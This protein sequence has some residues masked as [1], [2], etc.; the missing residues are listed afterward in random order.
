MTTTYRIAIPLLAVLASGCDSIAGPAGSG[1]DAVA[2]S[3]ADAAPHTQAAGTF[4]QTGITSLDA[5]QAGPNT[6]LKQTSTGSISGTLT[7]SYTDDLKVVIHP[8]G[9]FNAHF[10]ILCTCTVAG[11]QGT[12]ELVASDRGEMVSPT[13]AAFAGRAVITGGSGDL[14]DVRG[15]L[16]IEGTI[17]L[18][19]G[20]ATYAYSGRIH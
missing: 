19:T 9:R 2:L 17:D 16:E 6:I 11:E 15:V 12:L 10:T 7:G 20:L 18:T 13:V 3:A 14:A 1:A 8:N 5:R 4:S